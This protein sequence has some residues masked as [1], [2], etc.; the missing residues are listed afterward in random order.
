MVGFGRIRFDTNTTDGR[1]T[2]CKQRVAVGLLA[3]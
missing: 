3:T 1:M 2:C